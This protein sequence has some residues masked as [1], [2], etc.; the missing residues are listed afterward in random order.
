MYGVS[1]VRSSYICR[2]LWISALVLFG[3]NTLLTQRRDTTRLIQEILLLAS[4][5]ASKYKII[6][7]VGLSHP[8]ASSY[9][10]FLLENGHVEQWLDCD[11]RRKYLLTE[12][13]KNL[14]YLLT[15]V[16]KAI[17]GLFPESK[18]SPGLRPGRIS[19]PSPRTEQEYPQQ[20][21]TKNLHLKEP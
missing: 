20:V 18:L 3:G 12:K 16:Q 19:L 21:L 14:V 11:H 7:S 15:T 9:L 17:G 8:Q 5:G 2:D 6:T 13:G 1:C 10:S 4:T